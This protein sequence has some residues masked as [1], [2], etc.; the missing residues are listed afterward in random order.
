MR[1][2]RRTRTWTV[3]TR[4]REEETESTTEDV[5]QFLKCSGYF[6]GLQ[7]DQEREESKKWDKASKGQQ[8]VPTA[9]NAINS[10]IVLSPY[11]KLNFSAL[12]GSW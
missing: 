7:V 10:F 5:R 2:F 1:V 12:C 6:E 11:A 3:C 4:S 9:S 8:P